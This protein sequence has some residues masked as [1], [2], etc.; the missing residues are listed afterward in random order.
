MPQKAIRGERNSEDEHRKSETR[1][2]RQ[3]SLGSTGVTSQCVPVDLP[4]INRWSQLAAATLVMVMIANLQY[5]WT[6][7]VGPIIAVHGWRLSDVQW[8]FTIF[9]AVETWMM[10]FSGYIIDHHGARFSSLRGR[11]LFCGLGWASLGLV[12]ALSLPLYFCYALAGIGAGLVYSGAT[13][14]A[15][16]QFPDRR[17]FAAGIIA[18]GLRLRLG[19]LHAPD[20]VIDSSE[21]L[22][23]GFSRDGRD[24]GLGDSLRIVPVQ[25]PFAAASFPAIWPA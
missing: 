4:G 23:H 22:S 5:A 20:R 24:S 1:R 10:P 8:G 12:Q 19:V 16:R 14:I 17:G 25:R 13:S 7:F 15:L 21:Q 2:C 6:M 3:S 18:A 9:I 11:A